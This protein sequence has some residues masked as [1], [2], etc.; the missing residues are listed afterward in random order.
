MFFGECD[1]ATYFPETVDG[2]RFRAVPGTCV[3]SWAA[4][5]DTHPNFLIALGAK[6]LLL[7]ARLVRIN[8]ETFDVGYVS[9]L[10]V[11]GQ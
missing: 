9:D 11:D 2:V 3:S 6:I 10:P 7:E 5:F 4:D 8:D 1:D